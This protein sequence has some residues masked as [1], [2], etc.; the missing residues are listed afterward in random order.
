MVSRRTHPTDRRSVVVGLT[1]AG[2]DRLEALQARRIA[3]G[4]RRGPRTATPAA[5]TSGIDCAGC[6]SGSRRAP[7]STDARKSA[8]SGSQVPWGRAFE[9]LGAPGRS[10]DGSINR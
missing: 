8:P 2:R 4:A 7:P 5:T 3:F 6:A 10:E 1:A 9:R